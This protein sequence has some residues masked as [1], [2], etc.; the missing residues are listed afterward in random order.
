[1]GLYI[2]LLLEGDQTQA[3]CDHKIGWRSSIWCASKGNLP[4]SVRGSINRRSHIHRMSRDSCKDSKPSMAF[5]A[6]GSIRPKDRPSS[7]FHPCHHVYWRIL[8]PLKVQLHICNSEGF[9]NVLWVFIEGDGLEFF[10]CQ[11]VG[12]RVVS[13]SSNFCIPAI[14]LKL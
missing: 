13:A 12:F 9:V 5:T 10:D 6:F 3:I 11:I 8:N 1:M 7:Y 2:L 4:R 14:L